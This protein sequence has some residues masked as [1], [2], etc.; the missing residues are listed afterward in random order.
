VF[1]E[2]INTDARRT[3]DRAS[4][5]YSFK[6]NQQDETLYNIIYHCQCSTCFGRRNHPKHVEHWQW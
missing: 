6:Y 2:F 1:Q 3:R 4:L 5:M